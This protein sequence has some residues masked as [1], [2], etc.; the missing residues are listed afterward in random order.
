MIKDSIDDQRDMFKL[1]YKS[2]LR[3]T[4]EFID[5]I[6][7]E[8]AQEWNSRANRLVRYLDDFLLMG[9]CHKYRIMQKM[10]KIMKEIQE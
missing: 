5:K 1:Y 3:Q 4:V 7:T 10:K 2:F 9:N 8:K 6:F